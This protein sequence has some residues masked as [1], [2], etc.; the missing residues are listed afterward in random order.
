M[1]TKQTQIFTLIELLVVIAIIAILAS[2]LLPA[3]NKARDR[4]KDIFCKSNLKQTGLMIISYANDNLGWTMCS[5]MNVKG[6]SRTWTE[7]LSLLGYAP[8]A[9]V[10]KTNLFVCPSTAPFGKYV[11]ATQ[12]YGFRN[13]SGDRMYYRIL[14]LPLTYYMDIGK[15][16]GTYT[17]W[18][19]PSNVWYLGDSY[20]GS[21]GLQYYAIT[22]NSNITD[23]KK[24]HT[25]HFD[26]ANMLFVDG[27]IK[28]VGEK[29][30]R[31]QVTDY[32]NSR[33]MIAN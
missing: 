1:K 31:P 12:A 5:Y 28:A 32:Y 21:T 3:L 26:A 22:Y 27:H 11:D 9:V 17:A 19:N 2:M 24:P 25:R 6:A 30:L 20:N 8:A 18:K 23:Y 16:R 13:P 29:E 10:N 33:G 15:T 7:A 4:S 14:N